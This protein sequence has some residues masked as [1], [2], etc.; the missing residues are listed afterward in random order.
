M[1]ATNI[2][3]G[4]VNFNMANSN[5]DDFS[6]RLC[7]DFVRIV[8]SDGRIVSA[9]AFT[10]FPRIIDGLSSSMTFLLKSARRFRW[11]VF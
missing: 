3:H 6:R 8:I 2:S 9:A 7:S 5:F 4:N 11:V 10:A 1:R